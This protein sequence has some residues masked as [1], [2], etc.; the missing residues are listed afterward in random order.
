MR[1]GWAACNISLGTET[2]FRIREV[3][4]NTWVKFCKVLKSAIENSVP[5]FIHLP[6]SCGNCNEKKHDGCSVSMPVLPLSPM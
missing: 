2:V 3:S 5:V 1:C 4:M 6:R